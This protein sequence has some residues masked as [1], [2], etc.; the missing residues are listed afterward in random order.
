MINTKE[1]ILETALFLFNRDGAYSVSTRHIA[2]EMNISPGNLYYHFGNREEIIRILMQRMT[3]E[4]DSLFTQENIAENFT[5][6]LNNVLD[7]T[8]SIMYRY[9]FFYMEPVA[10]LE[11]DPVLKKMYIAIKSRRMEDFRKIFN[12]MSSIGAITPLTD[13]EFEALVNN[14]W[15][16]SE[17]I[18]QS[19]YTSNEKITES[20]I[21][22]N[23]LRI[24]IMIKPY[25]S[26]D[27]RS[28][29]FPE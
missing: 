26:N 21:K 1:K 24:M 11:R 27:F 23:F 2:D 29:V 7:K 28:I 25:L 15:A 16:L 19:M 10:I 6:G 12:F 18:I 5:S 22:K 3:A 14:G 13:Y 20:N 4:F 17:F 8:G 9:R